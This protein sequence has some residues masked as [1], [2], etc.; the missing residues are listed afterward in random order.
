MCVC[1]LPNVELIASQM[2]KHFSIK[3]AV[4]GKPKSRYTSSKAYCASPLTN[5]RLNMRPT[6]LKR[7]CTALKARR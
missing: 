4:H 5:Q 6:T 1:L 2:R 3:S 7:R